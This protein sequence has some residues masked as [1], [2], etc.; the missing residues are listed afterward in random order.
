MSGSKAGQAMRNTLFYGDNL[1][2]LQSLPDEM[3]DLIYLDPP[4]NSARSY[5]VL[6]KE[7]SG[8]DSS[9]QITAF[10]D[11]WHW[12]EKAEETYLELVRAG[13]SVSIMIDA[14][15]KFIGDNQM[16]AYLVMMAARLVKLHRV[17]KPTGSL[18]LHCDP[19]ASHYLK[20][21]L[22]TIFGA[23]HFRNEIIWKRT[24]SHSDAKRCGS[25]HDIVLF[26]TKSGEYTWNKLFQPFDPE[27]VEQYYRYRDEDGRRFMSA[28]LSGGGDGPPRIFG[29]KGEIPPPSGRHWMYDQFG[30]DKA[31]SEN[32]IFWT[33]NGVP[34]LK[35]YLDESQGMPLHDVWDDV[36][37]LR[38][39]HKE[40]LGYPTQKPVAL[41]ERIIAASSNAGDVVLDPFCGCG[42]AIAAAQKL[43]RKWIGIDITH[44]SIALQKYRLKDAFGLVA[45]KDYDIKGE[46]ADLASAAQLAQDDRYQFQW[47]ALSLIQARP[48]GASSD[49]KTG[50]KGADQG[51]D[52]VITFIDDA[53]GTARR[54]IVQV[55]S[56][57]VNAAQIRD[58]IGTVEREKAGIG[59]FITLEPATRP[60]VNEALK[61]SVY[62]SPVWGE[63][64]PKIQILTIQEL[65]S[66]ATVKLPKQAAVTFKKAKKES[67]EPTA[68]QP[69]L[70][71]GADDIL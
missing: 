17:L 23:E 28:D 1:P 26:Y 42:T 71:F 37:A 40:L 13:G 9:A 18:Y 6:F 58:L 49:S 22:D 67:G 56:G 8:Q 34:R 48:L 25:V 39:W 68:A 32:R 38:S 3:A 50:K 2:V 7:E 63:D 12:N 47:W 24:T 52:G 11:T 51:I 43:A 61:A 70:G 45:G 5:N 15:R 44:L 16:M 21:V 35:R 31:I 57:K 62:H 19:T 69:G 10:E 65:L 55:K 30:I 59:V 4:F 64:Y 66:G 27:Y 29:I 53:K 54:V 41:L 20:V 60:M 33:K 46:P 14:M 36:Q